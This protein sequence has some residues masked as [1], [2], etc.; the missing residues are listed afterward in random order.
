MA[1]VVHQRAPVMIHFYSF[2]ISTTY[3]MRS[4]L[5]LSVHLRLIRFRLVYRSI[6]FDSRWDSLSPGEYGTH[7][8]LFP[9]RSLVTTDLPPLRIGCYRILISV[10][11]PTECEVRDAALSARQ[12]RLPNLKNQGLQGPEHT[13]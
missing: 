11:E 2:H 12:N 4:A 3:F 8:S 1:R 7:E 13:H 10:T 5:L 9:F 6:R